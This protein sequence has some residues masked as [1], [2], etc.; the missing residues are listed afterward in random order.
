MPRQVLPDAAGFSWL[1]KKFRQMGFR[2]LESSE[3]RKDIV[4]F[5]AVAPHP[6]RGREVGFIFS[7]NG[8]DIV[9]WTTWLKEMQEARESDSGW[10]LIKETGA[11]LY[12]SHEIR[13]TKNFL[14]NLLLNARVAQLRVLSR[15]LCPEC[16]QFMSIVRGPA[17][18][19]RYWACLRRQFHENKRI[20]R[21]GWDYG[22][23]AQALLW[24]RD[25]RR[26]RDRQKKKLAKQ[27]KL[28]KKPAVLVRHG[29]KRTDWRG[30]A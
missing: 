17:I 5:A 7:A 26:R 20:Q 15:P 9:A 13:R 24:V 16:R 1:E 27:G 12:F 8:L 18:K 2:P 23:S 11:P 3:V 22:L 14:W 25:V 6:R 10:V 29:W 28:P 30:Q 21:Y 19:S 4:R